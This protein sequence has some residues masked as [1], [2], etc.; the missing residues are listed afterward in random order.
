MCRIIAFSA[1]YSGILAAF[2]V[3]VGFRWVLNGMNTFPICGL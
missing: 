3:Q 2:G 1:L